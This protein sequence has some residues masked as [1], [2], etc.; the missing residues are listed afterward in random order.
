M[1]TTTTSRGISAAAAW[2]T[3]A[4]INS[5]ENKRQ[6]GMQAS[7]AGKTGA[8]A[9]ENRSGLVDTYCHCEL[10]SQQGAWAE[11]RLARIAPG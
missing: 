6:S 4:R 9:E 7:K 10:V 8:G 2:P 3:Q 11:S 1:L 5:K